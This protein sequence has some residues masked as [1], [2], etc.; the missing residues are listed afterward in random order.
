MPDK[1]ATAVRVRK[2][3]TTD[4]VYQVDTHLTSDLQHTW[5][6]HHPPCPSLCPRVFRCPTHQLTS[7][8]CVSLQ[9]VVVKL[10]MDPVTASYFALF[11]V[12]NHTF[13]ELMDFLC[14]LLWLDSCIN[15]CNDRVPAC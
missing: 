15:V 7:A 10:G 8:S 3:S 9:A 5:T 2:N 6:C 1:T 4:Q 13:C 12:I 11:E 14:L